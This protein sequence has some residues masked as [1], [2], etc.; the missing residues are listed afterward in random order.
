MDLSNPGG[1]QLDFSRPPSNFW[2]RLAL[3]SRKRDW[4]IDLHWWWSPSKF[5]YYQEVVLRCKRCCLGR[6]MLYAVAG[7]GEEATVHAFQILKNEVLNN[8]WSSENRW[9]GENFIDSS[10][11]KFCNPTIKNQ[12]YQETY[13]QMVPLTELTIRIVTSY[14]NSWP[15][16]EDAWD[17]EGNV[18]FT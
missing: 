3:C 8:A 9:V 5:R 16:I 6:P 10:N 18:Y 2:P 4:K 17:C 13:Q 11:L 7:Y 15:L 14:S 12:R 1:R